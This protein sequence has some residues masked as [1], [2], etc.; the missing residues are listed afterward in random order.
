MFNEDYHRDGTCNGKPRY[1][2][3][4]DGDDWYMY[5]ISNTGGYLIPNG[6]G[7][8]SDLALC[9][10]DGN[11]IAMWAYIYLDYDKNEPF[12]S[13]GTWKEMNSGQSGYY[14]RPNVRCQCIDDDNNEDNIKQDENDD[15]NDDD[16]NDDE[17]N[18][19]GNG[20]DTGWIDAPN[21]PLP[22]AVGD[23]REGGVCQ[24]MAADLL[25]TSSALPMSGCVDHPYGG[26]AYFET[27]LR[28]NVKELVSSSVYYAIS[29]E[30]PES[31]ESSIKLHINY[32][33]CEDPIALEMAISESITV[34]ALQNQ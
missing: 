24:R 6:S 25:L 33:T 4:V 15:E 8:T 30:V 23:M 2:G 20:D 27:T 31:I 9:E 13:G 1:K 29:S 12:Y 34:S 14:P 26:E 3:R 18:D 5:Y 7:Y 17:N 19:V 28:L 22:K 21:G 10:E 16:D 32:D 11:D